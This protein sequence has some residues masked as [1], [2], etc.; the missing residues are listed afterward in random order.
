M[1]VVAIRNISSGDLVDI[2]ITIVSNAVMFA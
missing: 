1:E 2:T